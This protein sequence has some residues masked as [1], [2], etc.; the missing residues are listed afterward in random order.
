MTDKDRTLV[1]FPIVYDPHKPSSSFLE[2]AKRTKGTT[3]ILFNDN[4]SCFLQKSRNRGGGN[5]IVRPFRGTLSAGI[6]TGHR[7]GYAELT[8]RVKT[9]IDGAFQIIQT[10]LQNHENFVAVA[11][12][13]R[14]L[15]DP[16]LGSGIF[17]CADAVMKYITTKIHALGTLQ[18]PSDG[19]GLPTPAPRKI[20][21]S[22]DA[23]SPS[24]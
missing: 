2:I 24:S 22:Q 12:S 4:E 20:A 21:E 17:K 10:M 1:V 7:G 5:A 8:P 15:K 9:L 16:T 11:Y 19:S 6:P 3:L 14:S 13:A 23:E 18:K